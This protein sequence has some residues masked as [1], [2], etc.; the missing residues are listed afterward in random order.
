MN[1]VSIK[2]NMA[3]ITIEIP[4]EF[5]NQ[6]ASID[7]IRRTVY[8][9]FIIEQWQQGKL[10]LGEAAKLLNLTYVEFFELLGKKGLSFINA[11]P[12]ELQE[13]YQ[14]FSP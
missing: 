8:E 3:T 5:A 7:E 9:D 14:T 1:D 10:S 6:F 2:A 13:S 11:T 4:D 12:E